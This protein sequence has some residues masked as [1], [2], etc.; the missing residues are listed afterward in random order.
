[1][2]D[3]PVVGLWTSRNVAG[4]SAGTTGES[5]TAIF[6]LAAEISR[7]QAFFR[8][9]FALS[10]DP[11]LNSRITLGNDTPRQTAFFPSDRV[12][13]PKEPPS[14]STEKDGIADERIPPPIPMGMARS[15]SRPTCDSLPCPIC[16]YE[17]RDIFPRRS[18]PWQR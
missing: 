4:R 17:P 1:M 12:E 9:F 8:F 5:P 10:G 16:L 15:G 3:G 2:Y 18:S 11:I 6:F 13:M 7:G 14:S